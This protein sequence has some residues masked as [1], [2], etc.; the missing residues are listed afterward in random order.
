MLDIIDKGQLLSIYTC[1]LEIVCY[2]IKV[3]KDPL[4]DSTKDPRILCR[5]LQYVRPEKICVVPRALTC[6]NT[7]HILNSVAY[8]K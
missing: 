4:T 8:S 2:E 5:Y 3:I 7:E 1:K 6:I